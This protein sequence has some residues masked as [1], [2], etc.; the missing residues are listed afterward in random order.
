MLGAS[1]R[2]LGLV[3]H[4]EVK[5]QEFQV[6]NGLKGDLGGFNW[7]LAVSYSEDLAKVFTTKSI[8]ASMWPEQ[9]LQRL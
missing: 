5:Q 6:T 1:A 8:N 4:I 3:P 7:D 2:A 9:L